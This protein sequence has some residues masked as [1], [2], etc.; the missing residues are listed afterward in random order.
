MAK[1]TPA[2]L[3]GAALL[4]AIAAGT[5]ARITEAQA[6]TLDAAHYEV[7]TADVV[8]GAALVRLTDAGI[9]AANGGAPAAPT[10]Q[11]AK[12]G[13]FEIDDNVAMPEGLARRRAPTEA[14]YP[15]DKLQPG[16]S[17]HV[18][19]SEDN[20]EPAVR[21]SSSVSGAHVRYSEPLKDAEG[22]PIMEEYKVSVYQRNEDGSYAKGEDG[23][24]IKIGDETKTREKRG[25]PSRTFRIVTV[26]A[27]DP[28]GAGA[29]VFRVK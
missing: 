8:D 15:F 28:R 14:L 4:S 5:V 27:T 17:F 26:D 9:A 1:N 18:P 24:R 16:Q 6:Q 11:A 2:P 3:T 25:E 10:A 12:A 13:A 29:R 23:K 7:N 20:P 21:L 19:V 22:N